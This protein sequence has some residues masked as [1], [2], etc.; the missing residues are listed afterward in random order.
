MLL[1]C[2]GG[3]G[4]EGRLQHHSLPGTRAEVE[5]GAS[6]GHPYGAEAP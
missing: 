6:P 2:H 3:P 1:S 5:D 4:A